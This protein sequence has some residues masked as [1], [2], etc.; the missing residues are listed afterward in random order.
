MVVRT[1][2][3]CFP[4]SLE[5]DITASSCIHSCTSSWEKSA[6]PRLLHQHTVFHLGNS[7]GSPMHAY[8]D[9]MS[10]LR[11]DHYSPSDYPLPHGI[12]IKHSCVFYRN[13]FFYMNWIL[14]YPWLCKLMDTSSSGSS[15]CPSWMRSTGWTCSFAEAEC[16]SW[17]GRGRHSD[18]VNSVLQNE[19]PGLINFHL[20]LFLMWAYTEA[21]ICDQIYHCL[22]LGLRSIENLE[23]YSSPVGTLTKSGS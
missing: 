18:H 13:S 4:C 23:Q 8:P 6:F 14:A 11:T 19:T 15:V 7:K 5:C 21:A 20:S 2:S 16:S 9:Q 3:A 22:P 1:G 17:W 10:V 12:S